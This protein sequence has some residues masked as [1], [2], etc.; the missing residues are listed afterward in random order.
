MQVRCVHCKEP[1]QVSDACDFSSLVC[2]SCGTN[3]SLV[4][5]LTLPFNTDNPRT[6]GHFMLIEL[7]GIGGFGWLGT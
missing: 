6:I 7:V 1:I 5:D 3:F 2:T 4:S